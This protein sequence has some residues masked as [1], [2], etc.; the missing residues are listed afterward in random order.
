MSAMRG[1]SG[2]CCCGG[3]KSSSMRGP[4][5]PRQWPR[6]HSSSTLAA[7]QPPRRP[8]LPGARS[9]PR[10]RRKMSASLCCPPPRHRGPRPAW[11]PRKASPS[12]C[13]KEGPRNQ[14]HRRAHPQL[15]PRASLPLGGPTRL[16]RPAMMSGTAPAP[17]APSSSTASTM[18]P[19]Q[20]RPLCAWSHSHP[21]RGWRNEVRSRVRPSQCHR[22]SCGQLRSTVQRP[23]C[24]AARGT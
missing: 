1:G 6:W 21:S 12:K 18:L 14:P 22:W 24:W 19:G 15:A 17:R 10:H 20:I 7:R 4:S 5:V 11:A 8:R 13:K 3:C 16:L 2:S 9:S 23:V